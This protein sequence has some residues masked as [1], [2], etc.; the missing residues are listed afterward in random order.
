MDFKQPSA[1]PLAKHFRQPSIFIKLPS[2]GAYWPQGA[3]D[4]PVT[5]EIGVMSLTTKD[6]ITLRTP[7]ALMNGQGV[8][9]VI[10]S[11]CPNIHDAWLMP[12][13]DVDAVLIAI[14]IASYGNQMDFS[15]SCPHCGESHEYAIN[16]GNLLDTIEVPNYDTV[17]STNGL[18]IKFKPQ[19]YAE[20]NKTNL[21]A[22]EEQQILRAL[23]EMLD[24]PDRAKLDFDVH[25][26]K[27][28]E[29]N[30]NLLTTSTEYIETADGQKVADYHLLFE[31]Y[32]NADSRQIKTIQGFITELNANKGLKPVPVNCLNE[33][34]GKEFPVS[35]TFDYASFFDSG[36]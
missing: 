11:C 2:S 10:E 14:R 7:D 27:V 6:E 22:F 26:T 1:N 24:S 33:A 5:G 18:R 19:S 25:L 36:S 30:T 35:I 23:S 3:I 8:V 21:I 31:F 4:L 17:F 32:A 13:L 29:L 15:T 34:C 28:I 9:S 16:L 20:L 12:S